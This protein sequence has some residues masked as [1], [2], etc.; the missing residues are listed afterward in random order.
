MGN[1]QQFT[2]IEKADKILCSV[3]VATY[4]RTKLLEKLLKSLENQL[5][6][7]NVEL[8]V[9]IVDNDKY[10]NALPIVNKFQNSSRI[11]FHYF[12]QPIKNLSITRNVGVNNASGD[13]LLFI[14]DDEVASRQWVY[15]LLETLKKYDADG[16][17]GEL[18]PEFNSQ[19][20]LWMRRRD[21]FY[22][23]AQLTGEKVKF[24]YTGNC[25][26]KASLLKN[27]KEPFDIRYTICGEDTHLFGRLSRQGAHLIYCKE[28]WTSEYLPTTRTRLSNIFRRGFR[29]GNAHT[30]RTIEFAGRRKIWI[31]LFM[32]I[33]GLAFG[34]ISFVIMIIVCLNKVARAKWL[35]KLGSNIG[36]IFA[37]FGL[38]YKNHR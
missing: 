35:I 22:S 21:L 23:P 1:H 12:N 32:L 17:F 6:P 20:P 28:A 38:H 33:K 18:R 29:G 24:T 34:T 5:L 15:C 19:T 36:R 30:R 25:M 27:M 31:R 2:A 9:I 8:E 10:K 13:Y 26:L 11:S 16:V 37:V 3:C 14:D 4:L 7:E